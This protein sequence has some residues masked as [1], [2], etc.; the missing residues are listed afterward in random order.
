MEFFYIV[1]ERIGDVFLKFH[2]ERLMSFD[3][4]NNLLSNFIYINEIPQL[5]VTNDENLIAKYKA[6][7]TEHDLRAMC[8]Q[9]FSKFHITLNPVQNKFLSTEIF[10]YFEVIKNFNIRSAHTIFKTIYLESGEEF[11]VFDKWETNI[12]FWYTKMPN[13]YSSTDATNEEIFNFKNIKIATLSDLNRFLNVDILSIGTS[14]NLRL[15][16][17]FV[18]GMLRYFDPVTKFRLYMSPNLLERLKS[19]EP[20]GN[21]VTLINT[22]IDR[23][24]YIE[25]VVTSF[26]LYDEIIPKSLFD[27]S[28]ED[29]LPF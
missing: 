17:E 25:Y 1:V 5:V 20:K 16:W 24:L 14:S 13:R 6:A 18:D 23:H 12:I 26:Y 29:D 9:T 8:A 27:N 3:Q 10:K 11:E 22:R 15:N 2:L 7:I 28:Y 19:T 21:I 4:A